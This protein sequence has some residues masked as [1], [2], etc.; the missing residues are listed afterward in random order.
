METFTTYIEPNKHLRL[1]HTLKLI[2]M[3]SNIEK[4]YELLEILKKGIIQHDKEL[5]KVKVRKK[6]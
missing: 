5:W 2:E 3:P 1:G 6:F 4:S